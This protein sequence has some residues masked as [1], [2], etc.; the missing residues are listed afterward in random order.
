MRKFLQ[1]LQLRQRMMLVFA[2]F[3]MLMILIYC[4]LIILSMTFSEDEI[5]NRQLQ[6][7][8]DRQLE[9]YLQYQRFDEQL[10]SGMQ[11]FTQATLKN[12]PFATDIA[13]LEPGFDEFEDHDMHLCKTLIPGTDEYF[14]LVYNVTG[15]EVTD[16]SVQYFMKLSIIIFCIVLIIGIVLG[17]WLGGVTVR[18]IL[19]LEQRV[20]TLN[21]QDVFGETDSFGTDEVGSLARAFATVYERSQAFLIRE[22]RFTRE[23][24]HELRTPVAVIQG[25]L[26]VLQVQ[27]DNTAALARMQRANREMQQL[28]DTFLLLGREE[29][30]DLSAGQLDVEAVISLLIEQHQP[31]AAVPITLHLQEDP[32]LR[33]LPPVFAV[34]LGNLLANAVQHTSSGQIEVIVNKQRLLLTD[35]GSG[36]P[37]QVLANLGQA[38]VPSHEGVGLGLS[39][40]NRICQQFGWSL[41]VESVPEQGS[42]VSI[43][44][45]QNPD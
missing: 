43:W 15:Q 31:R 14:Y 32:K 37:A 22:K 33:I 11:L 7:E 41:Q 19:R 39:I 16:A 10:A 5:F 29:N 26:D 42:Q 25:A 35:T 28:I 24:S 36:F 13:G 3:S 18:P 27:P 38:Y 1:R 8:Q 30:L 23:V 40:V 2:G 21:R 9:H 6:H 20:Q 45:S 44:F 4:L 12:H 34:L 17:I